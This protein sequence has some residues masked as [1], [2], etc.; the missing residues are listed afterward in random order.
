MG[1]THLTLSLGY[2]AAE[3]EYKVSF[4]TM[5][6]LIQLLKTEDISRK[7]KLRLNRIYASAVVIIDEIGNL[8]ID[9]KGASLFFH[10]ISGL[11]EQSSIILTSNK[12]F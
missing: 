9:H 8:S 11:H 6:G 10:L 1:K 4:V 3:E 2:Q 12:G 5:V 7:S